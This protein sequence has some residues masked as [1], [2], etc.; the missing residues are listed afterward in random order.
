MKTN[1]FE[2]AV[3]KLG[4]TTAQ[5]RSNNIGPFTQLIILTNGVVIAKTSTVIQYRLS[6]MTNKF[7]KEH[8]ELFDL[9]VKYAK[10]PIKDR[11]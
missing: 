10:T 8:G 11:K 7:G 5:G 3:S 4:Y 1:E 9:L 6:T 2:S